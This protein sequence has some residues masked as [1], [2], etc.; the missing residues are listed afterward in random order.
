[1]Q[2]V[3][4]F[5]GLPLSFELPRAATNPNSGLIIQ[6]NYEEFLGFQTHNKSAL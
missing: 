6:N 3:L 2:F 4:P 5:F 1:M